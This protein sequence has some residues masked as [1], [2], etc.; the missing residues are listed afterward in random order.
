[1]RGQQSF[2][3]FVFKAACQNGVLRQKFDDF[4]L[5][6]LISFSFHLKHLPFRS[7]RLI[8]VGAVR[9]RAFLTADG[10]STAEASGPPPMVLGASVPFVAMTF[11][12]VSAIVISPQVER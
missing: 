2:I 3:F 12:T 5:G 6:A 1:M 9:D 10:H 7:V 8:G 4:Q 11:V